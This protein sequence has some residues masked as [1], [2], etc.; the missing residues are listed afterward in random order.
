MPQKEIL[1]YF[2]IF[3][4]FYNIIAFEI[5]IAQHLNTHLYNTPKHTLLFCFSI[6]SF[7]TFHTTFKLMLL[8]A[9]AVIYTPIYA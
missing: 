6:A 4:H 9:F 1:C 5:V 7:I 2:P 8:I 3:T